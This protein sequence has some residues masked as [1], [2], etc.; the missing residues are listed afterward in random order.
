MVETKANIQHEIVSSSE[1]LRKMKNHYPPITARAALDTH[2]L[3]LDLHKNRNG[4]LSKEKIKE[5]KVLIDGKAKDSMSEHLH[6]L[7]FVTISVGSEG[8]KEECY[9]E[10]AG[11][12]LKGEFGKNGRG[13]P[14]VWKVSDVVEGTDFAVNNVSGSSSVIT[15]TTPGGIMRTPEDRKYM[16][17]L[18]APP[19]A[20][21]IVSLSQ[22][23]EEN[24]R[25]LIKKLNIKPEELTQVTLNTVDEEGKIKK[26]RS[27][28][29]QY[30]DAARKIGVNLVLINHGDFVPGV[31]AALDPEKNGNKAMIVV[32]RSGF[33]EA[34]MDAAAAKALGGFAECQEYFV[35]P[36][37]E[38]GEFQYE[39][40]KYLSHD[41]VV[42]APKEEILVSVSSI[43]GDDEHFN[44]PRVKRHSGNRGHVV[45]TLVL[46]HDTKIM[47]RDIYLP[48]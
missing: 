29:Q 35:L 39:L 26:E 2:S 11:P 36:K 16:M 9:G 28:N 14:T 30:I 38:N 25:N 23:H 1:L 10:I 40:G 42:P 47:H 45:R 32:G 12:S 21:G 34:T 19:Q 31:R 43:T 37:N 4:T 8:A 3:I 48:D 15:I 27:I 20:K 33:E 18:I 6:D 24:L 13:Y 41:M 44:M 17:K 46:T 5:W 22:S 7:P